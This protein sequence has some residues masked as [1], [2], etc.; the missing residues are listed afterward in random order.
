MRYPT[1]MT[2]PAPERRCGTCSLCCRVLRV[3]PLRKLGGVACTHQDEGSPTPCGIHGSPDRP[4]LCG[5][6]R[7]AWLQGRFKAGDRPDQLGAVL[8]VAP[9]VGLPVLWIHEATVGCFDASPRLQEIAEECRAT[10]EVR[11]STAADVMNAGRPARVLLPRQEEHRIVGDRLT[12]LR[13]GEVVSD[14]RLPLL[15]RCLRRISL[16][17]SRWRLRKYPGAAPRG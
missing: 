11:I 4:A 16:A 3:E 7:C 1:T 12:V 17:W 5:A 13:G 2:E 15:D 9:Q 10:M 6:Y 8:D 14:R